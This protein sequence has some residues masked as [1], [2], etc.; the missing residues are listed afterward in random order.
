M[1]RGQD[2]G[3]GSRVKDHE[4]RIK[5]QGSRINDQGSRIKDQDLD[6]EDLDDEHVLNVR[7]HHHRVE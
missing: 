1:S 2:Q 4:S 3:S 7:P 6:D 5:D